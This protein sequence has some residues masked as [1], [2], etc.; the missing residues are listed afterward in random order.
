MKYWHMPGLGTVATILVMVSF[1][2]SLAGAQAAD[3]PK[4]AWGQPD[5]QG[6][7]DFRTI[8][9]LQRP[10]Q[11]G[12][13]A[14]LTREEAATLELEA[15]SRDERLLLASARRTEAGGNV[16]ALYVAEGADIDGISDRNAGSEA[17]LRAN[18]DV[19][20]QLRIKAEIDRM[21]IPQRRAIGHGA[22]T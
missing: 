15:V 17:Y 8:T 19:P 22:R 13:R 3:S 4:T 20:P 12:D 5:L 16:G 6:V 1:L 9:P 7:W 2:P 21:W 11:F 10:E 14:F 18:D